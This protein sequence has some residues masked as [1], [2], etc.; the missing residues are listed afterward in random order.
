[1]GET[2]HLLKTKG[3]PVDVVSGGGTPGVWTV[4]EIPGFTEHRAGTY[5]YND[6]NTVA[7][8]A[9]TLSDCAMRIMATVV[10]RP[11]PDRA[12]LDAG[13]KTLAAD[14]GQGVAGHG[15]IVEYPDAV[16]AAL[17]E[18]HGHVDLSLCRRAPNIGER[19][20]IVPNHACVVSNLHNEVYGVRGGRVDVVWPVDA[21]GAVR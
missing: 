3:I 14:L 9:A 15:L 17:S 11:T 2:I 10:S 18:E 21:R 8:G 16:L 19:V 7:A 4:H 12:I 5:V 1:M 13:S 20:S 6:R